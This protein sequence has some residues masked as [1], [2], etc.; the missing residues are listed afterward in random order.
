MYAIVQQ[1]GHQYR[2]APGDRL[3]VEQLDAPVGSVV[4]LA[5]VLLVQDD[6]R[7]A[8]G[9]PAVEGARVAARVVAHRFAKKIRV[10][11]FKAKKRHRR[12][13]GYR[14]HITELR[15]EALLA[16]GEP[17]PRSAAATPEAAPAPA[18][19]PRTR[20]PA[21]VAVEE[22]APA[23]GAASEPQTG[24]AAEPAAEARP[25]RRRTRRAAAEPED[26][27]GGSEET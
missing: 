27:A 17:L 22:A 8:A 14:S 12:T 19:R 15:I 6:S 7:F 11:T 3:V 13:Q 10:F 24:I 9:A 26:Q 18:P 21:A 23:A 4:A 25:A 20:R 16:A 1:G 2:V 5:P